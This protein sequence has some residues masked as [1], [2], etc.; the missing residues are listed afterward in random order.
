MRENNLRRLHELK[1]AK[2]GNDCK[3]Y[4]QRSCQ[5]HLLIPVREGYIQTAEDLTSSGRQLK[6]IYESKRLHSKLIRHSL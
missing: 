2:I 5:V 3:K 1:E 4:W 6:N